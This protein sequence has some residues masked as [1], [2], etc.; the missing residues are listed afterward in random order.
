MTLGIAMALIAITLCSFAVGYVAG[1]LD[2]TQR[3]RLLDDL[4]HWARRPKR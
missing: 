2:G 1:W 3:S 4:P